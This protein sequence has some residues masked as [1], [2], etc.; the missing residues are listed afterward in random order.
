MHV[1]RE[2]WNIPANLL[3]DHQ[4]AGCLL[5]NFIGAL[6]ATDNDIIYSDTLG[7]FCEYSVFCVQ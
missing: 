7:E 2:S 5:R 1:L 6:S 3:S 4:P